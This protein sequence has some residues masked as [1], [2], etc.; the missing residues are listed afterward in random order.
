MGSCIGISV[1]VEL[2]QE[3]EEIEEI[4]MSIQ[5]TESRED[6]IRSLDTQDWIDIETAVNETLDENYQKEMEDFVDELLREN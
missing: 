3:I 4:E 1:D 5:N 2:P 6:S